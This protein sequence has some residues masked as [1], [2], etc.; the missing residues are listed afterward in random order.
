MSPA[1]T[2][3]YN[4]AVTFTGLGSLT[5]GAVAGGRCYIKNRNT[6][7]I[8]YYNA[9]GKS[10]TTAGILVDLRSFASYTNADVLE[11]GMM[12]EEHGS[13][14]HTVNTAKGGTVLT[15]AVTATSTTTHPNV[16]L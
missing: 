10:T 14:T 12:G 8:N 1:P 13:T 2:H 3:P 15:I 11:V 6:R 9:T 5:I 7:E 4:V 16:T